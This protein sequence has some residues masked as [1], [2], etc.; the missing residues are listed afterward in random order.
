MQNAVLYKCKGNNKIRNNTVYTYLHGYTVYV[1]LSIF[2]R[3]GSEFQFLFNANKII[4]E[5]YILKIYDIYKI[6]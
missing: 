1:N 6:A 3:E 2:I 5:K 4:K